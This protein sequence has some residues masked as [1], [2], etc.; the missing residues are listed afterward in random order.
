MKNNRTI[1]LSTITGALI[2]HVVNLTFDQSIT[3]GEVNLERATLIEQLGF[4]LQMDEDV[5]EYTFSAL[6][7]N[8]FCAPKY[9]HAFIAALALRLLKDEGKKSF[10]DHWLQT[11]QSFEDCYR[12]EPPLNECLYKLHH[13][14]DIGDQSRY[15]TFPKQWVNATDL[16]VY[17]QFKA[18]ALFDDAICLD[19]QTI[20]NFLTQFGAKEYKGKRPPCSKI[21]MYSDRELRCGTWHELYYPP[22]DKEYGK[23][24]ESF[25]KQDKATMKQAMKLRETAPTP[26]PLNP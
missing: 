19:H 8:G 3:T 23:Q 10:E 17:L 16:A 4:A 14:Y 1:N 24:A 26:Q 21:D 25:L 5:S 7:T 12:P 11:E 6:N 13:H 20:M 22:L 15:F 18:E 2:Q 9:S